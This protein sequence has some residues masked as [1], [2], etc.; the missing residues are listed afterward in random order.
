MQLVN[1]TNTDTIDYAWR[2]NNNKHAATVTLYPDG[3]L[4]YQS[5]LNVSIENIGTPSEQVCV[6]S[7]VITLDKDGNTV[8]TAP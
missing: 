3:L 5:K 7:V 1:G 2:H 6:G 8:I 4:E